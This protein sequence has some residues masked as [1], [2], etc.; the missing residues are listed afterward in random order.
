M[1]LEGCYGAA[2]RFCLEPAASAA[3][4]L[5]AGAVRNGCQR[6]SLFLFSETDFDSAQE[7]VRRGSG[8]WLTAHCSTL[9]CAHGRHACC[10]HRSCT[11]SVNLTPRQA[12][13]TA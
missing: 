4:A 2:L 10:T 1:E 7:E 12:A 11:A 3:R 5:T 6:V 9:Q 8:L 13:F